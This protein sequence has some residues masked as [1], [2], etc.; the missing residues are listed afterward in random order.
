MLRR[1]VSSV[2]ALLFCV[3]VA[4]AQDWSGLGDRWRNI[5]G[6]FPAGAPVAAL[7]RQPGILDLFVVGNDGRVYTSSWV[8]GVTD[9]SG[10]GSR[11]RNIGGVFP[12]GAQVAAVSRKPGQ[13]DLFVT[14]NDGRVYTSWWTEGVTDWSGLGDRWRNIGGVF[15][16]AAR[17]SAVARRPDQLD[18]FATGNDG[19]VY[20][21]WWQPA[22]TSTGKQLCCG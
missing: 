8:E 14:G 20:T 6:V 19:I 7:A 15:P 22:A 21:S 9:W 11:W 18:L 1:V 16:N 3:S 2:L 13:L 4:R 5:G 10:L 17:V 12:V